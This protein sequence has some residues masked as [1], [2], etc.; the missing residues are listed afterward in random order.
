MAYKVTLK[1]GAIKVHSNRVFNNFISIKT[2]KVNSSNYKAIIIK[3]HKDFELEKLKQ[4]D[5]VNS[6]IK[7]ID[8]EATHVTEHD[9]HLLK[10]IYIKKEEFYNE[11]NYE[12]VAKLR[13]AE[14]KLIFEISKVS[15]AVQ[16]KAS[17]YIANIHVYIVFV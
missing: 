10:G 6:V 15:N 14:W 1:K 4:H 9:F 2:V 7:K 11:G 13:D 5:D 16:R 3:S 17:F 8:G 12:A